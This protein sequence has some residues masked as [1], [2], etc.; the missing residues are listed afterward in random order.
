MVIEAPL[1]Y[2]IT[3]IACCCARTASG[4]R[5][6][7]AEQRDELAHFVPFRENLSHRVW[8]RRPNEYNRR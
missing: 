5:R 1:R 4:P 6:R 2:P 7:A 3:G 8:W